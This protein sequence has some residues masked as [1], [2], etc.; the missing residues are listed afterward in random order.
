MAKQKEKG[1]GK[2]TSGCKAWAACSR[3]LS[4]QRLVGCRPVARLARL[5]VGWTP[6][7]GLRLS[8]PASAWV[9]AQQGRTSSSFFLPTVPE[10]LLRAGESREPPVQR[11]DPPFPLLFGDR[12]GAEEDGERRLRW[13]SCVLA[14]S[15]RWRQRRL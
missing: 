5:L 1:K 13:V 7:L 2:L 12:L 3:G 6:R 9:A 15:G 11:R 10:L 8:W 14:A 4:A